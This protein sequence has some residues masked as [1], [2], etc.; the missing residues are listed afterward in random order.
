MGIATDIKCYLGIAVSSAGARRGGSC[1]LFT[2]R[3]N[4][5]RD[6]GLEEASLSD[7][8]VSSDKS[9]TEKART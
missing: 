5:R 4:S 7:L 1:D 3:G 2:S 8:N 6:G 9:P